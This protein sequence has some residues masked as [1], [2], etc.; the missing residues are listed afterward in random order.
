M[1][2]QREERKGEELTA[3]DLFKS[4]QTSK[5]DGLSVEAKDAI[6]SAYHVF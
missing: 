5:K 4:T 2:F 3:V 1:I 6:V